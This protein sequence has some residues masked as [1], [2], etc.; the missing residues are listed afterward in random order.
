[1]AARKQDRQQIA[2]VIEQY[3]RGFATPDVEEF[4]AIWDH[5]Y[6]HIIYIPQEAAE[7]LRDWAGVEHYY[8]H[9][10]GFF[11]RVRTMTVGDVS[12]EVF[13]EVAYAFCRFHFEGEVKGQRHLADGRNTFILHRKGGTWKVIHYHESRPGHLPALQQQT[14]DHGG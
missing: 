8:K 1:M 3:R 5:D 13:G 10:A 9:V 2:A 12:V 6:D 11:T 7:P 4:T 14:P